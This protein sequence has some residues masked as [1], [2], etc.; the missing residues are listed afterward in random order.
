MSL[1]EDKRKRIQP[2]LVDRILAVVE[3]ERWTVEDLEA[4]VLPVEASLKS[5]EEKLR[6]IENLLREYSSRM[7]EK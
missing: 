1:S 6:K 5:S 7:E 3:K 2:D 4:V